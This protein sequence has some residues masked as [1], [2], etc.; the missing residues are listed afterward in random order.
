MASLF[1][2]VSVPKLADGRT[3]HHSVGRKDL[4]YDG[5]ATARENDEAIQGGLG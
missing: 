2:L 5:G 4:G 1:R 3:E